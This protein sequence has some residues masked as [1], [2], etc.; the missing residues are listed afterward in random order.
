MVRYLLEQLDLAQATIDVLQIANYQRQQTRLPASSR[1]L[2]TH[3]A[4]DRAT[5]THPDTDSEAL[6]GDLI[7]VSKLK[8]NGVEIDL[9]K[10]LRL[11][12]RRIDR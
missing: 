5:P 2:N 7:R 4:V 6:W 1:T 12:K 11:L 8:W 3:Q 10:I 9:A